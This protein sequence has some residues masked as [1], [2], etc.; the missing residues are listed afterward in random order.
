MITVARAKELLDYDPLTGDFKWRSAQAPRMSVGSS[1]G[2]RGQYLRIKIDGSHYM[3]H[4]LAW[5]ITHGSWPREQIDHVDEDKFNN[6]LDNLRPASDRQN[7]QNVSVPYRNNKS[8]FQGVNFHKRHQKFQ[9]QIQVDGR[10]I[11]LGYF[12]TP[13]KAHEAY[14]E[15]K[16]THHGFWK[17]Q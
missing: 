11:H 9:A 8:G 10:K 6:R 12:D 15:A 14:A 2:S 3:A 7:K 16:R 1:A 4:R 17:G 13:E 5:L